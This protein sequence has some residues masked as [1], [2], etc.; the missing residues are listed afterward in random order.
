MRRARAAALA[1]AVLLLTAGGCGGGRRTPTVQQSGASASATAGVESFR[2][3]RSLPQHAVPVRLRIPAI[4]VDAPVGRLGRLPDGTLDVPHSWAL[5]GWYAGG[6][7]PGDAGPAVLLGHV[8]S[9][10]GPAV[11]ARLGELRP[12]DAVDVLGADGQTER[13]RVGSVRRFAK[14]RFPTDE[15]YLPTL[16]PELRLVTCGGAFNRASGHY[17]DNV[18]VFADLAS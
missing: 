9:F 8:D 15:V 10:S 3:L 1:A 11:F 2:A 5:V 18:I 17:V 13:F 7:R 6:P 12:G 4:A 14:S 16:R